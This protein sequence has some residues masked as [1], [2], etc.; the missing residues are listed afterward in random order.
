MVQQTTL[1]NAQ[2][3]R[4]GEL[5]ARRMRTAEA[6]QLFYCLRRT[7]FG[8]VAVVWSVHGDQP[9]IRRVLLSKARISA[10]RRVQIFF[11][12]ARRSSCAEID[13][14]ADQIMAF[15][16]GEDIRFSLDTVRLELCSQFQQRVLRAEHGIPRG[17]VST[18]QRIAKYLGNRNSARAVGTALATNPFPIIIPCHRAIRSD[19]TLGGYQGGPGMK[20]TLLK[21]EGILFDASGRI[22]T[23]GFFY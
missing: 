5:R 6:N 14:V 2:K 20:E 21:M 3:V 23:N 11:P 13:L 15:L 8:P 18:Y 17:S 4:S 12:D 7:P 22:V 10:K 1:P 19:G 9:R 16:A